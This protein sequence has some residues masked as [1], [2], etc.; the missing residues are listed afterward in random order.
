MKI[1]ENKSEDL[2]MFLKSKLKKLEK[3]F[4]VILRRELFCHFLALQIVTSNSLKFRI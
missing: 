3:A 1:Y 2:Y 4:I